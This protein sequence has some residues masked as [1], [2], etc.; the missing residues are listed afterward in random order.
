MPPTA[1]GGAFLEALDPVSQPKRPLAG[2]GVTGVDGGVGG[3][4]VVGVLI[5]Y[6]IQIN[7]PV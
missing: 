6:I 1:A 3:T 5:Y 4:G 2:A 7:A